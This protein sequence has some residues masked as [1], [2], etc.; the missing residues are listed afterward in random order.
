MEKHLKNLGKVCIV[1]TL[2]AFMLIIAGEACADWYYVHGH[3]G[4]IE[5]K[6]RIQGT[7]Y[8]YPAKRYEMG[9]GLDFRTNGYTSNWVH[10]AVPTLGQSTYG[11][12]YIK[13][14]L[15]KGDKLYTKVD[16]VHVY[17]GTTKVKS[18]TLTDQAWDG[19][20]VIWLDLGTVKT[21]NEGMGVSVRVEGLVN[22]PD[23]SPDYHF[24]FA[25]VGANF[26]KK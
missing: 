5:Y 9:W 24:K 17:N 13:V 20:K 16:Q 11:A 1:G 12:R 6:D 22:D 25:Y 7:D 14:K 2:L 4:H 18:F 15:Y 10:F 19:W 21:F 3:N 8:S 23:I 26:V